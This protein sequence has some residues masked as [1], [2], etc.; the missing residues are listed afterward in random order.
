VVDRQDARGNDEERWIILDCLTHIDY[1][2]QQNDFIARRQE[3]TGSHQSNISQQLDQSGNV[4]NFVEPQI[5]PKLDASSEV[6]SNAES[7]DD[8]GPSMD[9][10]SEG[11]DTSLNESGQMLTSHVF[12]PDCAFYIPRICIISH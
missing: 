7:E 8:D 4:W 11:S 1:A 6:R 10:D 2:P 12:S 3:G 5:Y 9:L